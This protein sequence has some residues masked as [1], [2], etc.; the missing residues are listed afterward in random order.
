MSSITVDETEVADLHVRLGPCLS[1][2]VLPLRLDFILG[3]QCLGTQTRRLEGDQV[4]DVEQPF[5]GGANQ[6]VTSFERLP[7]WSDAPAAI[8]GYFF[9]YQK[10]VMAG[11]SSP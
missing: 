10:F 3:K 1:S 9:G 5:S 2:S 6:Q 7:D 4:V 8:D 11:I